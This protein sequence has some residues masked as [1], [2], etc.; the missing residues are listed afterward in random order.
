MDMR[1]SVLGST[2]LLVFVAGC[3]GGAEL[4][5]TVG[6][7]DDA[8][9]VAS[10]ATAPRDVVLNSA[11][12]QEAGV[13]SPSVYDNPG[14][15]EGFIVEFDGTVGGVH[16]GYR[17]DDSRG[18]PYS[19]G[20][21]LNFEAPPT[22]QI[23]T[24]EES[25]RAGGYLYEKINGTF[26]LSRSIFVTGQTVAD[27]GITRYCDLEGIVFNN[28]KKGTASSP[29]IYRVAATID[30]LDSFVFAGNY[31][32]GQGYGRITVNAVDATP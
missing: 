7:W 15:N 13:T 12:S 17:L 29:H 26:Q 9:S 16:Y 27:H 25:V 5:E 21:R 4:D 20:I 32:D 8:I 24:C 3:S 18:A 11:A 23:G 19:D 6:A 1:L 14:C 10:C 30:I 2:G 22:Q 28:V 31:P